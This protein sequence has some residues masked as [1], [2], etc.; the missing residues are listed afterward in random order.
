[1]IFDRHTLIM[2]L[3]GNPLGH[4]LSPMMHN[5]TLDE[6]GVNGVYL[7]IEVKSQNLQEAV[8]GLRALNFTGV[9]VTIPF[10][11]SVIPFL[12]EMSPEASAC[13][14]VNLIKIVDGRLIGYNTD[15]IGF[16]SS[17]REEG[18]TTLNRV[19]VIGA[20]GAA[21]SVTYELIKAGAEHLDI[22]DIV[23]KRALDLA[24]FINGLGLGQA[25]GHV[26]DEAEVERSGS[27]AELIVNCSPVGMHPNMNQTPIQSF[28]TMQPNT[29]VYDLIYNPPKT[30]FLAMAEETNLKT[31]N[32]AAMLVHQGALTLKI[33]TGI[34]PPLLFMKEVI[35]NSLQK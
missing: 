11:Q 7:P 19:A 23:E 13:Q 27:N 10:K 26:M 5:L 9:N 6:M 14:A 33:L 21:Q 3:I 16:M 34:E 18:I 30:K 12:D 8:L 4:S 15:G 22:F 29:V 2:G 25:I 1:M 32:G 24:H 17:L 31:I 20:G 28:Q 35:R